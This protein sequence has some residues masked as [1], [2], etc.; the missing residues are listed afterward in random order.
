M[1]PMQ[2][3]SEKPVE[4]KVYRNRSQRH[5]HRD[6]T[7]ID[8]VKGRCENFVGGISSQTDSIKAKSQSGLV[9]RF[10]REATMLVD[11][12]DDWFR[13]NDQTNRGWNCEQQNQSNGMSERGAE[14]GCVADRGAARDQWQSDGRHGHTENTE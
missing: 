12:T 13:E 9:G 2:I 4:Q 8:R 3:E 10:R 1:S 5:E 11:E 14:A 6:I 7:P